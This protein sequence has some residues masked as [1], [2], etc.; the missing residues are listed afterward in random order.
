MRPPDVLVEI[1]DTAADT[2]V[3]AG[4]ELDQP[5]HDG[6]GLYWACSTVNTAT[7][8]VPQMGHDPG[9]T[10]LLQLR[11]NGIPETNAMLPFK[12]AVRKGARPIISLGGT[13]GTVHHILAVYYKR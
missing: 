2:D 7:V 9:K 13:T 8:E 11:A 4:T 3:F 1:E 12:I 6:I 10:S 5:K